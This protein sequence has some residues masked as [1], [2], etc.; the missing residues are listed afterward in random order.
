MDLWDCIKRIQRFQNN[1]WIRND[2]LRDKCK[3]RIR[4]K[5]VQG[6]KEKKKK[7]FRT[8]YLPS[9]TL[10]TSQTTYV[11]RLL[12]YYLLD[13]SVADIK[14]RLKKKEKELNSQMN[15]CLALG[16]FSTPSRNVTREELEDRLE[17][18]IRVAGGGGG[19][20]GFARTRDESGQSRISCR[21]GENNLWVSGWR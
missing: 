9:R 11:T 21:G 16:S 2:E 14:T 12:N 20:G 3:P 19:E 15:T 6:W 1:P 18:K 8:V 13:G 17:P 4:H 7:Y 5:G 10:I